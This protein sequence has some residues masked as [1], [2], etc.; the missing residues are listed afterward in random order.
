MI[1][2][3]KQV[4]R[5]ATKYKGK[6]LYNVGQELTKRKGTGNYDKDRTQFNVD[7]VPLKEKNLYQQVKTILK[8]RNIEYLKKESTNQIG[9]ASCRERV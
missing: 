8:D 7:Y 3:G 4:L 5:F 1:Y 6:D 9:R 2:D